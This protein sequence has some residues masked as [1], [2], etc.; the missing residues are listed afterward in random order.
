M[1]KPTTY[2]DYTVKTKVKNVTP[3]KEYKDRMNVNVLQSIIGFDNGVEIE[4]PSFSMQEYNLLLQLIPFSEELAVAHALSNGKSIPQSLISLCLTNAE[5]EFKR[6]YH[7]AGEERQ[8]KDKDGNTS[9]Y[10]KQCYTTEIVNV[11][12]HLSQLAQTF[13]MKCLSDL[14]VSSTTTTTTTTTTAVP[15]I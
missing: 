7:A 8:A 2:T 3:S 15:F 4:K 12:F 14:M 5:I 10:E 11:T 1:A 13:I 9:V 6:H